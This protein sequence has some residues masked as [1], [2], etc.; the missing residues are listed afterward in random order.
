[1]TGTRPAFGCGSLSFSVNRQGTVSTARP[2]CA[3]AILARQQNGLKRRSASVPARSYIV[4][5]IAPSPVASTTGRLLRRCTP[6]NDNSSWLSLRA[7][8]SNLPWVRLHHRDGGRGERAE[9]DDQPG[10]HRPEGQEQECDDAEGEIGGPKNRTGPDR[11][12][13]RGEQQAD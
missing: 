13:K 11:P 8:R 2:L 3:S 10:R 6:R 4:I 7:E 1:M 12:I 9:N 5:V